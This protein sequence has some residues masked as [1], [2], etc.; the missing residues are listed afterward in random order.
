MRIKARIVC[1]GYGT[2]ANVQKSRS[3][4][5]ATGHLSPEFFDVNSRGQ[6]VP[7]HIKAV[8]VQTIHLKIVHVEGAFQGKRL[9]VGP[10][11]QIGIAG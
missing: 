1:E 11:P 10:K 6:P 3:I 8:E 4:H 7:A 2:V 9:Q 5:G